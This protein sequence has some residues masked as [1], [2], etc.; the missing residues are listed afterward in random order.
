MTNNNSERDEEWQ[1]LRSARDQL[2]APGQ[3][4]A[5]TLGELGAIAGFW[6]EEG[7]V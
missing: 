2:G 4:S 3:D 6:A 7:R 1:E 5:L